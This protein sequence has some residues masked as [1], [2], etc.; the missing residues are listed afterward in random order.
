MSQ[1]PSTE[2]KSPEQSYLDAWQELATRIR[3]GNSFSGR[4]PNSVFLNTRGERFADV[5]FMSGFGLPDD[6]RGLAVSDWDRD[7]DLDL[8]VSNRTAPRLRLLRNDYTAKPSTLSLKLEG[9]PVKRTPRDAIGAVA[10]LTLSDGSKQTRQVVAGDGFV[11]QSSKWLHFGLGAQ[12][13]IRSLQV[14]WPNNTAPETFASLESGRWLLRQGTGKATPDKVAPARIPEAP[15][16]LPE[17]AGDAQVVLKDPRVAPI[18]NY[19]TWSGD[20]AIVDTQSLTLTLLWASWCQPCLKEMALLASQRAQL[21][22]AGIRLIA[23]NIEEAQAQLEGTTLPKAANLRKALDKLKWPFESGRASK[24]LVELVDQA[25][26]A[27]LYKQEPLP[28]PSSFLWQKGQLVSFIKG[29]IQVEDLLEQARRLNQAPTKQPDHAV[30]LA[31]RWSTEHFVTN[32]VA[33]AQVYMEGRYTEDARTYLEESLAKLDGTDARRRQFQEAD[34]HYALGETF[35]LENAPPNKA[36]P[37]YARAVQLNPEHGQAPLAQARALMAMRRG[38]EAVDVLTAFLKRAPKRADARLQLGN[39][40]Q[41]L[42]RDS[43]AIQAYQT[44]LQAKPNDFQAL[45]Q[46]CW[47]YATSPDN[48]LRNGKQA[49][50]HAQTILQ[51]YNNNPHALDTAAAALA[52]IGQFDKAAQLAK[53]ALA[54]N[55]RSRRPSNTL[56]KDLQERLKLYQAKKPFVRSRK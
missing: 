1:S 43:E 56:A 5:S 6:G 47:V 18:L 2:T 29:A 44:V 42:G 48:K 32:P 50:R 54:I 46:L 37:H 33:I 24:E 40:Q 49:M 26:R 35:R 12:S 8:W 31:G 16:A 53:R 25:Q 11:S 14:R 22:S 41:S 30:P 45:N 55:Q 3:N 19:K 51:R 13:Q 4:E 28:L 9:D 34:I 15:L 23:L 20:K 17:S 38:Q 39:V 21:E 10:T 52:S 7:G 27:I 36:L